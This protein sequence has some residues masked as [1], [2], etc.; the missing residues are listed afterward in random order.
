[1][2]ELIAAT[3]AS[4]SSGVLAVTGRKSPGERSA[5]ASP[6]RSNG[7]SAKVTPTQT[8]PATP[9]I[10]STSLRAERNRIARAKA[11]RARVLSATVTLKAMD[12]APVETSR[13]RVA[14]RMPTC[15]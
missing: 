10:K 1:M 7:R 9:S 11:A 4:T 6:S 12:F 14:L 13:S 2:N 5:I 15:P 8:M 3:S